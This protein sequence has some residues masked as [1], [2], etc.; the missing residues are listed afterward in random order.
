MV[1]LLAMQFTA[2]V[3][4]SAGDFIVAGALLFAAGMAYV[5]AARR[6][7]NGRQRLAIALLVLAVLAVTWAELAVGLFN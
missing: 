2:E 6:A 3:A 5:V 4:W 1:P 7:R